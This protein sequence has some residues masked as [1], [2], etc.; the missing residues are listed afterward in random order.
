MIDFLNRKRLQ[1]EQ[2]LKRKEVR[3]GTEKKCPECEET[4]VLLPG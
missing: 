1:W 4:M 3:M 2:S